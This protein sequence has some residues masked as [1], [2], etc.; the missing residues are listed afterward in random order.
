FFVA[1]LVPQTWTLP[2]YFAPAAGLLYL[3]L[4]QCMRHLQ[5][6]GGRNSAKGAALIR[7]I[8]ALSCGMI[9]LRVGAAA[10]HAPI[11]P[12]WPR[13]NLDRAAVVL[14]RRALPGKGVGIVD[15]I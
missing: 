10:A 11:E 6:W 15:F 9:L 8:V 13:G 14:V 7:M 12:A 1:G 2:H 5:L 3:I 4:L